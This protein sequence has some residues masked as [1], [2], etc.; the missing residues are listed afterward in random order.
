MLIDERKPVEGRSRHDDLEVVARTGAVEHGYLGGVG[1]RLPQKLLET[2]GRHY[3]I[4][5]GGLKAVR[6]RLGGAG[7]RI[8]CPRSF[9][10]RVG[11]LRWNPTT[12]NA[13]KL[14]LALMGSLDL[15]RPVC[16]RM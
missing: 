2:V 1:K 12:K 14:S 7:C 13:P 3:D 6:T 4:M 8:T 16:E 9:D 11:E 15:A 10:F 5:P